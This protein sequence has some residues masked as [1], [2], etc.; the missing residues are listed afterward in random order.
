[1]AEV[2]YH[3]IESLTEALKGQ[4]AVVGALAGTAVP[5]QTTLID[6]SIRARVRHF[7]PSDYGVISVEPEARKLPVAANAVK[8]QDYLKD[9][10][11]NGEISYSMVAC[12][13]MM[14]FVFN[15]PMLLDFD[16]HKA[17]IYDGGNANLSATTYATIADAI[18]AILHDFDTWKNR[19]AY[20]HDTI[21]SQNKALEMAKRVAPSEKWTEVAVETAPMMKDGTDGLKRG[22]FNMSNIVKILT[23][24]AFNGQYEMAFKKT[25]N[26]ALGLDFMSD[27]QLS[28]IIARRVRGES[29]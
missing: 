6:A 27:D 12:G 5:L 22:E 24:V 11:A 18:A 4:H 26:E 8:I 23:A 28:N 25:D 1:M 7:I 13:A 19:V 29:L 2:D 9:K 10:A 21:I 17:S 3:S 15:T 16:N 14:E 20:V